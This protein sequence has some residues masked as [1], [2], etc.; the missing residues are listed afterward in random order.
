MSGIIAAA[1]AVIG[2]LLGA[3]VAHRYQEKTAALSALRAKCERSHQHLLDAC[4]DFLAL[5]E[6]YRRAR[7]QYDRWTSQHAVESEAVLATRAESYRLYVEVRSSA[8]RLRLVAHG[9]QAQD[10][11]EHATYIQVRTREIILAETKAD[12]LARGEVAEHACD[13]FV[14]RAREALAEMT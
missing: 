6:D 9:L 13:A 12:M 10:L 1:I 11:A 7:A 5:A 3:V 14:V 4:A 8:F 2:T